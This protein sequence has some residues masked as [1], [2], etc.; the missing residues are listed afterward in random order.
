MKIPVLIP[1]IFDHPFT[2]ECEEYIPEGTYIKV[3][4]GK[5]E[6]TGV[7][8]N[9][10]QEENNKKFKAKKISKKLNIQPLKKSTIE[11]L[12]WFCEY[13]LIPKGMGLKLHL[14]SGEAI[15]KFHESDYDIYKTFIRK[16]KI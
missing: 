6:K 9:S 12:N 7:V 3:S 2:Y 14:L 10:F 16:K 5:S 8:W 11:F 13:N 4:F 1:N 15:E